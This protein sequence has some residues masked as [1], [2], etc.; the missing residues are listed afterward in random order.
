MARKQS[1]QP[2]RARHHQE[3]LLSR[4]KPVWTRADIAKATREARRAASRPAQAPD[5][6]ADDPVA[7]AYRS[8][9][10]PRRVA[11][12]A[13]IE[14]RAAETAAPSE[15]VRHAR[16]I[17][18]GAKRAAGGHGAQTAAGVFGVS[19]GPARDEASAAARVA[20]TLAS[21]FGTASGGD[22]RPDR[23]VFSAGRGLSSNPKKRSLVD[24]RAYARAAETRAA[25]AMKTI[26]GVASKPAP[27]AG[28]RESVRLSLPQN[29]RGGRD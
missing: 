23:D 11:P 22:A 1:R 17:R 18:P 26:G 9:A 2:L 4:N 27:T 28:R 12:A 5:A 15:P 10:Q 3:R 13:Q 6:S 24:P 21:V 20:P 19:R 14:R 8:K 29:A 7:S 16:I 25:D